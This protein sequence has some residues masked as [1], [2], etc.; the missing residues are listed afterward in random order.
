MTI[1]RRIVRHTSRQELQ[2]PLVHA[3]AD[4]RRYLEGALAAESGEFSRGL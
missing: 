4:F 2:S 1:S 3:P